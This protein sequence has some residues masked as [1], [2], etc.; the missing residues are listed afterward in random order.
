MKFIVQIGLMDVLSA[1]GVVPDHIIG[2]SMGE[3]GCAYADGCLTAEQTILATYYR[4]LASREA[5]LIKGAMVA[6]GG[7]TFCNIV[8]F[9][10][11]L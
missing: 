6:I 1:V 8:R 9:K 3:L 5:Q 10:I 2:H 7:F 11:L 4:G